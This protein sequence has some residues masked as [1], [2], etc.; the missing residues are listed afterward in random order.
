MILAA[1]SALR[2]GVFWVGI[3]TFNPNPAALPL[4]L[5]RR[6]L[7]NLPSPKRRRTLR[8]RDAF[9]ASLAD[10]WISAPRLPRSR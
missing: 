3:Q 2:R 5:A 4:P 10:H 9:C 6:P 8:G 7:P 1:L